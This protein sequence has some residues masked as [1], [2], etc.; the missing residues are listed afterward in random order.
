MRGEVD[1]LDFAMREMLLMKYKDKK[2]KLIAY[3][4][5]LLNKAKGNY[6]IHNKEI[7]VIILSE[8]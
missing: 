8:L 7:L 1:V 2:W 3:I 5:K 6:E 4:L